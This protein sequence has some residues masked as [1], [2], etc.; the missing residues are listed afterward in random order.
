[1]TV[2]NYVD[3]DDQF[4]FQVFF[5]VSGYRLCIRFSTSKSHQN[6]FVTKITCESVLNNPIDLQNDLFS[7][8]FKDGMLKIGDSTKNRYVDNRTERFGFRA[9]SC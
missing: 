8:C 7:L 9:W 3:S 2:G 4:A 1:M 5:A 6:R